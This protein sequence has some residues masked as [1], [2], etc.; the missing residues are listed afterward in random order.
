MCA[1]N[2]DYEIKITKKE[3][4]Y[5]IDNFFFKH[6]I[7]NY[8]EK[9]FLARF[10][11]E[12]KT[13]G[14]KFF[15]EGMK[16]EYLYFIREGLVTLE[17]NKNLLEIYNLI[18]YIKEILNDNYIFNYTNQNNDFYALLSKMTEPKKNLIITVHNK[19]IIAIESF[20]FGLNYLF[21]A[22]AASKK[23]KYYK[24]SISDLLKIFDEEEFCYNRFKFRRK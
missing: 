22:T 3:V 24:L 18:M 21:T 9:K 15:K 6:I 7:D 17:I 12:E 14:E 11:Y 4:R 8:F 1:F 5:L 19:D 16:V 13:N 20:F 23:V 10:I 2:F